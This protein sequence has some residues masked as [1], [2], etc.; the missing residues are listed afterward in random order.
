MSFPIDSETQKKFVIVVAKTEELMKSK[1]AHD[2]HYFLYSD[3]LRP[4]FENSSVLTEI[5]EIITK[6]VL[7]NLDSSKCEKDI[8]AIISNSN[9]YIRDMYWDIKDLVFNFYQQYNAAYNMFLGFSFGFSFFMYQGGLITDSRDFCVA[10]NN[11]VW[12]VQEAMSWGKWTPLKGNYPL[13]YEIKEKDLNGIPAYL[14]YV[15]Y[16][17]LID[18]GGFNCRHSLGWISDE[19]AFDSRPELKK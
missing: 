14:N 6:S 16:Y 11:K 15:D 2:T 1:I 7:S 9:L 3:L 8:T 12:S 5:K 18:R 19:T 13:G 10:H 17:P 4:V